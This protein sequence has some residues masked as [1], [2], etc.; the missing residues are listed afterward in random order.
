LA[1]ALNYFGY[2]IGLQHDY[3]TAQKYLSESVELARSVGDCD[4]LA[5][6]LNNFGCVLLELDY[7]EQ[8]GPLFVESLELFQAVRNQRQRAWV[9]NSLGEVCRYQG[10]YTRAANLYTASLQVFRQMAQKSRIAQVLHNLGHVALHQQDYDSAIEFF[11]ESLSLRRA[12]ISLEGGMTLGILECLAGLAGVFVRMD[13]PLIAAQL[14]GSV[15]T[16]AQKHHIVLERVDH[17]EYEYNLKLTKQLLDQPS[18]ERAWLKGAQ[19]N[20]PQL[21]TLAYDFA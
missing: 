1:R 10:D 9:L 8:A 15:T 17:A 19:L 18:W 20:T 11:C 3:Y 5:G 2:A 7:I 4:L 13:Q 12:E 21:L 16:L 14:W 6:T